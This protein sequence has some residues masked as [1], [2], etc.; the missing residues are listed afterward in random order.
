MVS[1]MLE[2]NTIPYHDLSKYTMT[3]SR[4][5]TAVRSAIHTGK[6]FVPAPSVVNYSSVY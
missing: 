1:C 2:G 5:E 6:N 4:T 3:L